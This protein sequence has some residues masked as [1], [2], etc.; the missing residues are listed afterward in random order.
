MDKLTGEQQIR[1]VALEA[2]SRIVSENL[3]RL[4]NLG[5]IPNNKMYAEMAVNDLA[6]RFETYVRGDGR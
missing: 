4:V 5:S 3:G 2:A 6:K 1:A